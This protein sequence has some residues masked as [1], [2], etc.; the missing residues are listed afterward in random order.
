MLHTEK[1]MKVFEDNNVKLLFGDNTRKNE[2]VEK[3]LAKYERAGVPLYLY[4]APGSDEAVV[5]PEVITNSNVT[6]LFE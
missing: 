2:L 1:I 5:L 3:W 6:E 4:F